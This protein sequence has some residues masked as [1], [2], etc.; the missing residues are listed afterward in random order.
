MPLAAVIYNRSLKAT[1]SPPE[2]APPGADR[3][4]YAQAH[5]TLPAAHHDPRR[6]RDGGRHLR[7]HHITSGGVER[8]PP[9]LDAR[10]SRR[11]RHPEHRHRPR[12]WR[13]ARPAGLPGG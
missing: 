8:A 4:H 10:H 6:G 3:N 1:C 5:P 13:G 2:K 11:A 9:G 12:P 7:R